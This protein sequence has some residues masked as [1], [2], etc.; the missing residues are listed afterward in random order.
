MLMRGVKGGDES[1][2]ACAKN[3]NGGTLSE[4]RACRVRG[5]TLDNPLFFGGRDRHAP[6][7]LGENACQVRFAEGRAGRVRHTTLD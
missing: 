2:F 1:R 5:A 4:G 7:T 3:K 6:P